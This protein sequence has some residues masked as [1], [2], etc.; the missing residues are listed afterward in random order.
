MASKKIYSIEKY[1]GGISDIFSYIA[2]GMLLGLMFLGAVDVIGRYFFASP[3]MGTLEVSEILLAGVAFFGWGYTQSIKGHV[4][5][6]IIVSHFSHKVQVILDLLN[7]LLMFFLL[8][9]ILWQGVDTAISY[10][11]SNRWIAVID[12]PIFP[13]QLFVPLGALAFCL[14]LIVQ[15]VHLFFNKREGD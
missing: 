15:I 2:M 11:R 4:T 9:L 3:I 5:V 8:G 6:K 13:F 14:V 7:S 12:V 10:W 1:I